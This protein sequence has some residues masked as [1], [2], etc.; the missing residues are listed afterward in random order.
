[1]VCFQNAAI[2]DGSPTCIQAIYTILACHMC[3]QFHNQTTPIPR[4]G[5]YFLVISFSDVMT[6]HFFFLVRNTGSWMEIGNS[7]SH[8]GIVSAQVVFVLLLFALT[9]V[10]TKDIQCNSALESSQKAM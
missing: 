8:F 2:S 3:F 7:I 5:C 4:L 6:F 1:M 9:N 10:Y